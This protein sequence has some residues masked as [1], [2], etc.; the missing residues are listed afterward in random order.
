MLCKLVCK[1]GRWKILHRISKA[2]S[3]HM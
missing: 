1:T 3:C 2:R